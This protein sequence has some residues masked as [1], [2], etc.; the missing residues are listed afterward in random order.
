MI[1]ASILPSISCT[2]HFLLLLINSYFCLILVLW[3]LQ[4]LVTILSSWLVQYS[5]RR[6]FWI[7]WCIH[8]ALV[9][10][11]WVKKECLGNFRAFHLRWN[12]FY[13]IYQECRVLLQ[14]CFSKQSEHLK[15]WR[16]RWYCFRRTRRNQEKKSGKIFRRVVNWSANFGS[17]A[18][19]KYFISVCDDVNFFYL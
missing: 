8:S 16:F 18:G 14:R 2:S 19:P 12:F 5:G 17:V 3:S 13:F 1:T 7:S 6:T 4:S 15:R 9:M 10:S 11:F